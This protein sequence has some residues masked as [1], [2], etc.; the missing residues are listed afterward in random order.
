M[1][2]FST[3]DQVFKLALMTPN[4]TSQVLYSVEQT[5]ITLN[6]NVLFPQW[7]SRPVIEYYRLKVDEQSSYDASQQ[8][9]ELT[10]EQGSTEVIVYTI[11]T[12]WRCLALI[13]G[14]TVVLWFLWR[15]CINNYENYKF[16]QDLLNQLYSAQEGNARKPLVTESYSSYFC[17]SLKSLC[18]SGDDPNHRKYERAASMLDEEMDILLVVKQMR[19]VRAMANEKYTQE[20]ILKIVNHPDAAVV[21]EGGRLKDEERGLAMQL[22]VPMADGAGYQDVPNQ[23]EEEN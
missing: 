12:I 7:G 1:D 11:D 9:V 21:G 14:I 8:I 17:N 15:S 22:G 4:T 10:L 18:C 2:Y 19:L 3:D 5:M 20:Q 13:G 6:S 23:I 16:E